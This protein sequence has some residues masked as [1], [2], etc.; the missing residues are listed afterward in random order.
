MQTD[1]Q[2]RPFKQYVHI[3]EHL[4]FILV[5]LSLVKVVVQIHNVIHVKVEAVCT[6]LLL[7]VTQP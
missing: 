5:S 6:H 7:G 4:F 1:Y 2:D 3:S